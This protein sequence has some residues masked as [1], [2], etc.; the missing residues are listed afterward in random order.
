MISA[1]NSITDIAN[2][3]DV[4]LANKTMSWFYQNKNPLSPI[5][6][7]MNGGTMKD[8]I[9]YNHHYVKPKQTIAIKF[10]VER[11]DDVM[12]IMNSIKSPFETHIILKYRCSEEPIPRPPGNLYEERFTLPKNTIISRRSIVKGPDYGKNYTVWSVSF[13][14]SENDEYKLIMGK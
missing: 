11:F 13:D 12:Q 9:G 4:E 5:Q 10:Y 3:F 8:W 1:I 7:T 2:E 6:P 14:P